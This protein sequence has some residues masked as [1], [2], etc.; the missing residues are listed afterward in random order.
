MVIK[1]IGS[2]GG[3]V[4]ECMFVSI[5]RKA[6]ACITVGAV[7]L[8]DTGVKQMHST[9]KLPP[10]PV[11]SILSE[12]MIQEIRQGKSKTSVNVLEGENA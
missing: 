9:A 1:L 11:R 10:L 2:D 7:Y 3:N 4:W 6:W 8:R 12:A 5:S